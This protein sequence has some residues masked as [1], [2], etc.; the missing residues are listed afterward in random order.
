[1]VE[2]IPRNFITPMATRKLGC[3][4]L[5]V[6]QI[7][8]GNYIN[9]SWA[10]RKLGCIHLYVMQIRPKN[11]VN[12]PWQQENWIASTCMWCKSNL[13]IVS[14]PHGNKKIGLHPSVCGANQT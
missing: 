6:S 10:T 12:N 8:L 11:C 9:I 14:T 5:Y 13:K 2:I 1:V 3:I 4:H 7:K